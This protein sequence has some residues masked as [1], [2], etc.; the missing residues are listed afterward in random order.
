MAVTNF[1]FRRCPQQYLPCNTLFLC[2]K[3]GID[4][5]L[6]MW[7]LQPLSRNLGW[8]VTKRLW[9][10]RPCHGR[11]HRFSPILLDHTLSEHRQTYGKAPGGVLDDSPSWSPSWQPASDMWV[12]EALAG[13]SPVILS[14]LTVFMYF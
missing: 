9:F 6:K 10:L 13:E 2:V 4:S 5:L 3:F 8:L 14:P 11:W 12:S 7:S 1:V